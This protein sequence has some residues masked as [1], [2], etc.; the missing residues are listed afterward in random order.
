[1]QPLN[2]HHSHF[3]ISV[4]KRCGSVCSKRKKIPEKKV[5]A[6][7][8]LFRATVGSSISL[9]LLSSLYFIRTSVRWEW[10]IACHLTLNHVLLSLFLLWAINWKENETNKMCDYTYMWRV[11]KTEKKKVKMFKYLQMRL[12]LCLSLFSC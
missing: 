11:L 8:N 3:I 12:R 10:S 9:L 7:N 4:G 5:N 2:I 1:M 6:S